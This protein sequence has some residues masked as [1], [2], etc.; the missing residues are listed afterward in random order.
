MKHDIAELW[1]SALESGKYPQT[2]HMLCRTK[3]STTGHKPGFCCLGVLC[4]L[5]LEAGID[6]L[7]KAIT[8]PYYY[9]Q[10]NGEV[11]TLPEIV[12]EWAGMETND[13]AYFEDAIETTLAGKNDFGYS[14]HHIANI[15][16]T[17]KD[18]L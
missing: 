18:D 8:G 2:K 9:G 7:G 6:G 16:R 4:E 17:R 15:I 14:F 12:R 11:N 1:A 13:G 10:Y 3:T 5:A